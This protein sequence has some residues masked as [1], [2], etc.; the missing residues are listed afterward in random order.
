MFEAWTDSEHLSQWDA[1]KG[2]TIQFYKFDFRPSIA[3]LHRIR[4]PAS[5]G[6]LCKGVYVEIIV[7]ERIVY[8]LSFSDEEGNSVE[9]EDRG[10]ETDR[11]ARL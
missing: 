4:N 6:C 9:P 1:P 8:K 5:H 2:C 3:F 11:G 10:M 7:P